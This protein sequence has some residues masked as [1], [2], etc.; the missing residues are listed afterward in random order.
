MFRNKLARAAL[1]IQLGTMAAL[2]AGVGPAHAFDHQRKG[3]VMGG[4]VGFAPYASLKSSGESGFETPVNESSPG[5]AF[6]FVIGYA[7]SERNW[8]VYEG[9][10]VG[11]SSDA[12]DIGV[13]QGF[14]GVSWYHAYGPRG[15][16]WVTALGAGAQVASSDDYIRIAFN[17]P[18]PAGP[19]SDLGPGLLVGVGRE[20]KP[21]WSVMLYGTTGTTKDFDVDFRQSDVS[22]N[23]MYLWD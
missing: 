22:L 6:Q 14:N 13:Y 4:G 2:L 16:A 5:F 17:Q 10:V 8:L 1:W 3:F 20:F 21:R 11:R 15:A 12:Y 23:L 7:W 9:N 18:L 19:P